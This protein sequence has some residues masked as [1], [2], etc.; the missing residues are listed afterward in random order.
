MEENLNPSPEISPGMTLLVPL[1]LGGVIVLVAALW[2]YRVAEREAAVEDRAK[3]VQARDILRTCVK[4]MEQGEFARA[5]QLADQVVTLSPKLH[6]GYFVRAQA[7]AGANEHRLAIED[8]TLS[9]RHNPNIG[10][11]YYDYYHRGQAYALLG[12]D[13]SAERDFT[14]ALQIQKHHGK[15]YIARA[16]VRKR[17][18]DVNGAEDDLAKARQL[19][20]SPGQ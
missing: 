5:I 17:M 14:Q 7:R 10:D 13:M 6:T 2:S 8:Y 1:I 19:G 9:I 20:L 18:G 12:D 11:T 4:H 15:S 16:L 3:L